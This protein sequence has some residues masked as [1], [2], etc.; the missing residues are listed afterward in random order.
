M[1]KAPTSVVTMSVLQNNHT[2]SGNS[3]SN[4][5]QTEHRSPNDISPTDNPTPEGKSAPRNTSREKPSRPPR[6]S[7]S[8][9]TFNSGAKPRRQSSRRGD[10]NQRHLPETSTSKRKIPTSL[11]KKQDMF[12]YDKIRDPFA[13]STEVTVPCRNCSTDAQVT[14]RP[15]GG[16]ND[17]TY[18][19][20][21][22]GT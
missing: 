7:I 22:D 11:A 16:T 8:R 13:D 9:Q 18:D 21:D 19:G 10:K 14:T 5:N 2:F 4:I 6:P 20:T 3:S 17:E 15:P 12:L 1:K